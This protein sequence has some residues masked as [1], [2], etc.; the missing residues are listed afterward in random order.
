MSVL[1]DMVTRERY[2]MQKNPIASIIIVNYNGR[3]FLEACLA[4]LYAMHSAQSKYEIIVVNNDSWDNSVPYLHKNHPDVRVIE[5]PINRGFAGGNNLGV[6]KAKG[7]YVVL[8]NNDT[9]VEPD[10]L[11]KLLGAIEHAP[12]EVAVVNGKSVLFYPYI[13][14]HIQ[15]EAYQK[16]VGSSLGDFR[17]VHVLVERVELADKALQRLLYYKSGF[18]DKEKKEQVGRWTD[19]NATLLVPFHPKAKHLELQFTLRSLQ[20]SGEEKTRARVLFGDEVLEEVIFHGENVIQCMITIPGAK[21]HKALFYLVQNAGNV[22]FKNGFVRD[23]GSAAKL[24]REMYEV[25]N[26]YFQRKRDILAFCGVNVLLRRDVF[27]KLGGFDES[28]F[29]YYE[30]ADLS[31]RLWRLGYRIVYEPRAILYHIHSASSVEWSSFVYYHAERNHL[32]FVWKHFPWKVIGIQMIM[33]IILFFISYLRAVRSGLKGNWAK[34][35]LWEDRTLYRWKIIQWLIANIPQL[36]KKR[37]ALT[38]RE[39]MT[40]NEMFEMLY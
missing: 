40:V 30:D 33:H 17:P 25:D 31:L 37:W 4:S 19:G 8:L 10:W 16:T 1:Y 23:R 13:E 28:F 29:M 36:L 18:F 38:S 15:S 3:H 32:A 24:N 5:S 22:V 20:G 35:E 2:Q 14:I 39:K 26:E 11:T 12:K 27:L 7:K 6:Q 34:Y 21:L 9:T